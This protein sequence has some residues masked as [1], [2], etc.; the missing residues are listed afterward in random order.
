MALALGRLGSRVV[1]ILDQIAHLL[2]VFEVQSLA[3][4]R[5]GHRSL[6]RETNDERDET[7]EVRI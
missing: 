5:E 4:H 6:Y 2:H 1:E 3:L 7:T